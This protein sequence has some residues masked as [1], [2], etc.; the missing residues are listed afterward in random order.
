MTPDNRELILRSFNAALHSKKLYPPGHPSVAAPA[1]KT[2]QLLSDYIQ[3]PEKLVL[4]MV[5]DSLVF[6]DIP[7]ADA[8]EQYGDILKYL[9]EKKIEAIA[10]TGGI[11]DGELSSVIEILTSE[12]AGSTQEE[13]D[14]E[15][16]DL[17]VIHITLQSMPVEKRN[18]LEV[19][20]DAISVVKNVMNEIRLG[21]IPGTEEVNEIV[22]EMSEMVF[23]NTN[24]MVGLS[25]IKNYDEYLYNHSVN[26]SIISLALA[27]HLGLERATVDTIG[28]AALL[29]DVG[30][31]G[32]AEDIIKKPG[33]LSSEEWEKV[34]EHPVIGSDIAERMKEMPEEVCRIIFEH[35]IRHDHSGYPKSERPLYQHS[36]IVTIC[37]AYDA[38]TTLRVYQNPHQPVDAIKI[39]RDLSGAHFTP[40]IVD[41]FSDMIG[42]YPV[43]TM[44]RLTTNEVGVVT[45]VTPDENNKVTVKILYDKEGTQLE[46]PLPIDISPK[47]EVGPTIVGAA[48]PLSRNVDV[49]AFFEK[50]AE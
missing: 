3:G 38:L 50:E 18:Y 1:R 39:L 20:N 15:L 4:A 31:T 47:D 26:V 19:Y 45:S 5:E 24:A 13:L 49:S 2:Q 32:V 48:D 37:D 33:G 25:M 27:R 30:K 23:T 22:N 11:E 34:K 16:K 46:E 28:V 36:M 40:E 14:K 9:T 35:H 10:F 6:E 7:E 21:K 29:H 44:V 12:E 43:G 41:A 42:V 8:A 17:G